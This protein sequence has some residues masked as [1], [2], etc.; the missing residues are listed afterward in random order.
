MFKNEN[1]WYETRFLSVKTERKYLKIRCQ[2]LTF[3]DSQLTW[4][5]YIVQD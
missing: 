3:V 5:D 2:L 4:N 1:I